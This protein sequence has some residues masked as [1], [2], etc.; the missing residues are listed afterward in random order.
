M[1]KLI[2]ILTAI[3]SMWMLTSCSEE[4][5]VKKEVVRPVK[6]MV[7]GN[8]IDPTGKGYPGVTKESIESEISFRVGGPI[9]KY[10]VIEGAEVK[11]GDIVAEIDP[12]DYRIT[13]Q[14]TQAR[15]D[16]AKAEAD[17]YY[18]LWKKGSVAKN[19]YDRRL[20][21]SLEAKAAL[22]DA[23]NALSDTKLKAPF[24]GF[25]GPKLAE[26]GDKVRVKQAITTIVDLS[27]I[28][29]S[30]TIPEQLAIQIANFDK[31][32]VHLEAY[33]KITFSA[34]L[35]Q[36]EKKP[37][38]E[39]FPLRLYLD[40]VNN[41]DDSSSPKVGAGMSCRVSI[42][43]NNSSNDDD[44]IVIPIASIFESQVDK[45]TM[46]WIID[47]DSNTVR[48]QSVVLG[49]LVGN[50]AVKITEGLSMGQHIVIAGVHRLTEGDKVN[51]VDILKAN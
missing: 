36:L 43:L 10:N 22:D 7:I 33:P 46:V 40:H 51:N 14:S 19:D 2:I 21:N 28:E 13:V 5:T 4:D 35:K 23:K 45:S 38:P 20:A 17:R 18:R 32:E 6:S 47:A 11:K 25:Y 26:V 44:I 31:Y 34:K 39:G 50:D 1:N 9:V 49:D 30:T 16:Q 41:P 24:S 15:Y 48:K 27:V 42:M 29:I 37:T 12:R 8:V 3:I